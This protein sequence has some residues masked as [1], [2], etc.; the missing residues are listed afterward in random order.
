MA[1]SSVLNLILVLPLLGTLVLL[2][3]P[4][5]RDGLVRRLALFVML[6]VACLLAPVYKDHVAHTGPNTRSGSKCSG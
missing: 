6:V 4:P 5:Q 2:V 1:E 3:L